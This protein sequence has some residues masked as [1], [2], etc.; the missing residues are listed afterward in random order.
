MAYLRCIEL[1]TL[2]AVVATFGGRGLLRLY[3]AFGSF[4]IGKGIR[5]VCL[6]FIDYHDPLYGKWWAFTVPVIMT[7]QFLALLELTG[8]IIDH[9]PGIDRRGAQL[10][11]GSC[12]G[13]GAFVGA[14]SSLLRFGNGQCPWYLA[15]AVGA[16]KLVDWISVGALAFMSV[17]LALYPEP[18]QRNLQW[19]RW[20]L[21]TYIGFAPGMAL[22]FST[23]G[24]GQRF[25]VDVANWTLEITEIC[26]CLC[27]TL[28]MTRAGENAPDVPKTISAEEL[29]CIDR[30]YQEVFSVLR[31]QFPLSEIMRKD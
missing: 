13:F 27:W 18:I 1:A 26:C 23:V 11:F 2:I 14:I 7:L 30:D 20:L 15:A 19:H 29:A 28:V 17:W 25:M 16:S 21:A 22:M 24:K 8:K 3:P 6:L 12:V 31:E 5:T 4:L 9:Y 10:I